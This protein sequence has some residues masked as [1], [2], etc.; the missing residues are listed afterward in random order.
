MSNL[1]TKVAILG[2][3][4]LPAKYGGFETLTHHLVENLKDEFQFIVYCSKTKRNERIQSF[5]KAELVYF[6]FKA[7]GW[8]S[9]IYDIVTMVHAW[10]TVDKLLILGSSGSIIFPLK[11][12]FKKKI[13][14]NIGGIDWGRSKWN[15]VIR[16]YIR[17]SE[18][19]CVK[20]ADVVITDNRYIQKIYRETYG[21]ESELIEYGG[22]HV[23]YVEPSPED[24]EEYPFLSDRYFMSVS[25]AQ[26]DNNLHLL[27]SCFVDL[28]QLKLVLV[29]NWSTSE[30]GRDL[31]QKYHDHYS[32][33]HLLPAIYDSKEL[34]LIRSNSYVYIHTHTFCGT[35]PSLVEAM[36]LK[37]PTICFNAKTNVETT[38]SR[39]VYFE[40][41]KE[42]KEAISS[43]DDGNLQLNAETM[44]EI[45]LRR[46]TWEIIARKYANCIKN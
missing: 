5:N 40:T 4:G 46:Y 1:K 35:A 22:D 31:W 19:L 13:I 3:N 20:F 39:S 36:N 11:V 37:L 7:N 30:Y 28:P 6:P 23:E 24:L 25:R 16:K 18:Y 15:F 42:L 33:I 34:D 26:S 2:T 32:N 12:F 17:F 45:A 38:E 29:S 41:S 21:V 44:S 9:V 14:L 27:L 8:Q 10:F 43:F